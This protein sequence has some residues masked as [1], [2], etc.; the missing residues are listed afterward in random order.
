MLR[1]LVLSLLCIGDAIAGEKPSVSGD[2]QK[3]GAAAITFHGHQT[4]EDASPNPF[5]DYRLSVT[6]THGSSV[7]TVPGYYAADGAA[8]E[9]GASNGDCWRVHFLPDAEGDWNYKVSFVAGKNAAI[10]AGVGKSTAFDGASGTFTIQPINQ[11]KSDSRA[12]GLLRYVGKHYLQFAE[13]GEYFIKGGAD[14]PENFLAYFEFDGTASK[15]AGKPRREGEAA[16]SPLHHYQ[17]HSQDWRSGDPVWRNGQGKNIIGALNYLAGKGMNS[18]Y[19]LT[20]NVIGDGR[21]VWPWTSDEERLR[22]D[23]SK[24]DQWEI[25]FSH[26][27]RLGLMQHVITQET[28]NDQLLDGGELGVE[29]KLYYRELIARFAHHPALVWNLGEEN[30]NTDSQRKAFA[31]Y[32]QNIDPYKHPIVVHTFPEKYDE[33]YKPLLGFRDFYGPSLQMGDMNKTH[34]E[35]IKWFDRSSASSRPWFICVDEI[36][37]PDIGVMPDADD[38]A[39]DQAR[40]QALWGNLMAG[41]A[42]CEWYFGYK[43][44]HNDLNCED[45]RSR[46]R[47]WDMTRYALEFFQNDL[48]FAEMVHADELTPDPDDYVF[49]KPGEIYAI[50]MP[51]GGSP[52][53]KLGEGNYSVLW[54]NPR[55]GGDLREGGIK[56]IAGPGT[57]SIGAPPSDPD[58]DWTALLKR[59]SN[60]Q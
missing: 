1:I 56:S 4:S 12:K 13:T 14:S 49:A 41:G 45:W 33:V 35:T 31:E 16:P 18:V 23:C 43:F 17:P 25:V 9:S 37:P 3:W 60:N 38:P 50:Y 24:L 46:E 21:D 26:M 29:R 2:L 27:D 57:K 10:D 42:G 52:Q 28:E 59:I 53:I 47:L 44:A 7:Y 30:T 32:I 48:P 6:F 34:S 51:H 15:Q 11:S 5:L 20:M 40:Q 55:E 8:G 39:H 19:F 36:G 58:K 54:F 22:F